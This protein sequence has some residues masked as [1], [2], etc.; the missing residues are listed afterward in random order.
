MFEYTT[1][2]DKT[3]ELK[4]DGKNIVMDMDGKAYAGNTFYTGSPEF[5]DAGT[6]VYGDGNAK[7]T[8]KFLN[9][10]TIG[11]GQNLTSQHQPS[12]FSVF[13]D[14]E[15]NNFTYQITVEKEIQK[16]RN[17]LLNLLHPSGMKL[18]G[19]VSLR[20]NTAQNTHTFQA[21]YQGRPLYATEGGIGAGGA[22]ARITTSNAN[23]SNNIVTFSNLAGA[24]LGNIMFA[25]TT[26]LILTPTHGPNVTA[27]ITNVNYAANQ[28]TLESNTWL[29]FA[30]VATATANANSN[31]INIKTVTSAY[32][33]INNGTFSNT[34]YPLMD[35]VYVGDSVLIN[36]VSD[37]VRSVDYINGIIYVTN[38]F[39]NNANTYLTVT[40]NFVAN[41]A[42][43]S[44]QIRIFGPI[45]TTYIPELV[46]EAGDT[47]TT[48]NEDTILL[49]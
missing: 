11:Q 32:N 15:Y 41:S 27:L 25:N 3:L 22:T 37:T 13:Q 33:I 28:V 26:T 20:S 5:S 24:N 49:G 2:P 14:E 1:V 43:N 18:L 42:L 6:K 48:E 7:A 17:V 16:Y 44:D 45:G 36:G 47:L 34:A 21:V 31:T 30:N 35:I 10:L 39:V 40:R 8:A 4:I 12:S 46:T 19:R 38:N 29:T 9:G 23:K